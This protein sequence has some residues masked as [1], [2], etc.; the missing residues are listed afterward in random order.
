MKIKMKKNKLKN[1]LL[2]QIKRKKKGISLLEVMVSIF[3]FTLVMTM[4]SGI[5]FS[6][7]NAFRFARAEEK[8]FED[9]SYAV[10]FMAKSLRMGKFEKDDIPDF[11]RIIIWDYAQNKCYYFGFT[12]DQLEGSEIAA[13]DETACASQDF[14]APG[15]GSAFAVSGITGK[16]MN[17]RNTLGNVSLIT[18]VVKSNKGGGTKGA[19]MQTSVS[20]RN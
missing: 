5:F 11:Q 10:N 20:L 2:R 9:A 17:T 3:I 15:A 12:P 19:L 13:A 7:F 14:P 18:I 1:F 4:V 6:F 16:F 8:A